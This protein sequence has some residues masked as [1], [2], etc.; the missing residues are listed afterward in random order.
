MTAIPFVAPLEVMY[1]ACVEVT[2]S[3]RRVVAEN[4]SKFTYRGTGTYIIGRDEVAVVDPGPLLD[5]HRDALERALDGQR[6]V[7]ILVTHCHADHSPLAAWM[8]DAYGAPTYAYGPHGAV[9]A[10]DDVVTEEAIDTAFVPDVPLADGAVIEG[11][12]WTIE[13]VFTPGHTS[14][15]L[16]F[17]LREERALF[18]GDHVMGWST[19]VI[20]PPDGNMRA[21]MESLDKLLARDDATLWPT[22]GGPVT[23][24]RPFVEAYRAHRLERE[25]QVLEAVRRGVAEIPQIVKEL[26]ADVR[27]ELHAPAA[28]SV[29]AHLIKLTDDGAVTAD[30]TPRLDARFMLA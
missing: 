27:E 11:P 1:G 18:T 23:E 4:P 14:N 21:Y 9:D 7:A 12:G 13:A 6:V 28:R 5:S 17:A 16:C 25:A 20:A 22:H 2:P 29:L 3:I 8:A 30:P 19:T 26:Y 24:P 15:H 10:D